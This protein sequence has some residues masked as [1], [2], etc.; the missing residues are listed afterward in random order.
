MLIGEDYNVML[1]DFDLR[2]FYLATAFKS[3]AG[4]RPRNPIPRWQAPELWTTD[5]HCPDDTVPVDSLDPLEIYK[6][7]VTYAGDIFSF[8]CVCVEVCIRNVHGIEDTH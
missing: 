1:S 4:C 3:A 2:R 5:V 7:K 6:R 8:G